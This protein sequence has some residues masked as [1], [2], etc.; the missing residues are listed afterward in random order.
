MNIDLTHRKWALAAAALA[1][2]AAAWYCMLPTTLTASSWPRLLFGIAG[3]ALMAFAGLLPFAKKL[4]KWRII[5][6]PTMQKGHIWLGLLSFPL[7]LFH[8]GFR[9][10]GFLSTALLVVISCIFLSGILG[11]LF[12]H[13]LPLCKAGK[14]GKAK[15]AAKI[16]SASHEVTVLLHVPLAVSLVVLIVSHAFMSF[17][18]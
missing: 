8:G 12:Q 6:L 10:G 15:L 11:L 16:I 1:V 3:T 18:F 13:L 17:F 14:E 7:V 2:V 5:K 4:A 9:L